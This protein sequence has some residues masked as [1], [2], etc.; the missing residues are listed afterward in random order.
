MEYSYSD[1]LYSDLHKDAY[2]FRPTQDFHFWWNK[3]ATPAEKQS[4]W[5][6]AVKNMTEEEDERAAFEERKFAEVNATI[7]KMVADGMTRE[8]AIRT[9][10]LSFN[11]SGFD[12]C[13]GGEWVCFHAQISFK[14]HAMFDAICFELAKEAA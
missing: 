7:D 12:L 9:F 10:I 5:D 6:S 11:P 2:G 13:Y 3:E 8:Q 14:H 4:W 1:E